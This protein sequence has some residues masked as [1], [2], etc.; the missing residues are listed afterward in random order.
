MDV[1]AS[2]GAY[3]HES[4]VVT[5]WAR[6]SSL[7][8]LRSQTT[9]LDELTESTR[10]VLCDRLLRRCPLLLQLCIPL[11]VA[12]TP[13]KLAHICRIEMN[14]SLP[15]F[16]RAFCGQLIATSD[17]IGRFHATAREPSPISTSLAP[18]MIKLNSIPR[19]RV[20]ILLRRF[21]LA[22][23]PLENGTHHD[24]FLFIY[25][26]FKKKMHQTA[27]IL[28]SGSALVI[29]VLLLRLKSHAP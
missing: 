21:L 1:I 2:R 28:S 27:V 17:G 18:Y 26:F 23:L 25:F 22:I 6:E 15:H 9:N 19:G 8:T 7:P 10:P 13:A 5:G 3:L 12:L 29:D 24:I 20:A 14:S 16:T 11:L 4:V